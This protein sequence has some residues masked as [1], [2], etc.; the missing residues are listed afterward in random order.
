MGRMVRDAEGGETIHGSA[1][2]L[3]E[4]KLVIYTPGTK[5]EGVVVRFRNRDDQWEC[6]CNEVLLEIDPEGYVSSFDIT[7]RGDGQ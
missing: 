3:F 6:Y 4:D 5:T 2:S 1:G 7:K